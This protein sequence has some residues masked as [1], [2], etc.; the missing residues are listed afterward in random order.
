MLRLE[1]VALPEPGPGEVRIHQMAC[2]I[3]F[4]DTYQR[5]GLYKVPLP[6]GAG[7]EGAGV[8]EAVGGRIPVLF[9]SGIRGGADIFKAIAL[10]ATAV[11]VGRPYVYG[12]A[13]AG[14]EGVREVIQNLLAEFE[15]TMGLAGCKSV[16]EITRDSI[17][18]IDA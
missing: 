11:C 17:T 4:L 6:S 3:N 5:S 14:A 13:L 12:L 16:Q 2:G 15:L 1:E 8:V 18:R 10:G 7:N 9:D